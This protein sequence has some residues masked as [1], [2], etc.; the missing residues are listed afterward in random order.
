MLLIFYEI[1]AIPLE[2]SFDMEISYEWEICV[3]IAFFTDILMNFNTGYYENGVVCKEHDLILWNYMQ[4]WF[5]IDLSAS[6]P[7]NRVIEY[8]LESREDAN[9]PKANS[10]LL[11]YPPLVE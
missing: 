8:E 7:Y 6:F 1:I 9:N 5:W 11:R 4:R 10:S 2:I 3:D